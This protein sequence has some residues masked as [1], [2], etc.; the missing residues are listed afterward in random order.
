MFPCG[1]YHA[2]INNSLERDRWRNNLDLCPPSQA[3]IFALPGNK[4]ALIINRKY[5]V[6]PQFSRRGVRDQIWY[7]RPYPRRCHNPPFFSPLGNTGRSFF[8]SHYPLLAAAILFSPSRFGANFF[9]PIFYKKQTG[10]IPSFV[11][12][13]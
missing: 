1:W 13:C 10:R 2:F 3:A 9:I 7:Y 6:A 4:R 8:Y 5:W 12:L 11:H